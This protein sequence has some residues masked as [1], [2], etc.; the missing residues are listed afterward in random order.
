MMG[1]A[2][3]SRNRGGSLADVESRRRP[4]A[5]FS[6]Y[7]EAER[8]VDRLSDARFPVERVS[9]VGRDLHYV[10]NVTGRM[11][12]LDALLRGAVS[13]AMVGLLIGWLFFVFDWVDPVVARG[14][15][16]LDGLWFGTLIGALTGLIAHALL[17]GRRDFGS[18]AGMQANRY[19]VLVDDEVADEATRMLSGERDRAEAEPR[20]SR[21]EEPEAAETTDP[22]KPD[23]G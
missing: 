15:L 16:I 8:A 23:R 18:V 22:V 2:D 1:V 11:G 10:E 4:I 19:D 17:R 9:I 13:G 14:W 6:S 3:M 21:T 7:R 5:S 20:F 12:W